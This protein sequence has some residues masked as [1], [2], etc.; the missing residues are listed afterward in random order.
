MRPPRFFASS[1]SSVIHAHLISRAL[2]RNM[3]FDAAAKEKF[4]EILARQCAFSQIELVTFCL[5]GNH[6]HLLVRLDT[7][8]PNP[9]QD[10]PDQALL[11]HLELIYRADEVQKVAWQLES[12]RSGGF[13]EA[14]AK[15]RQKYLDRMRNIPCFMQELKQRFSH[16]HNRRV[17]RKGTVWEDRYKSVLVEDSDTAVRTMAAYIDLNPV[18]AGIVDDPKDY[19]WSGY[20]EAVAGSGS[21]RA[22]LTRLVR[23]E[24]GED[25]AGGAATNWA[26]I[27]AIYRCWL[28]EEGAAVL[29]EHGKVIKRGFA[30]DTADAVINRQQGQLARRVLVRARL[31]HFTEGVAIG[32]REFIEEL[33]QARRTAFS[34][35][36]VDGS[37]KM[38]GV[39][40]GGLRSMRD[41]R[42]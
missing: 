12:F 15:L 35:R 11:D 25:P 26:R 6:F 29:D 23:T 3:I 36:R 4:R 42:G 10:A 33:F 34:P 14:A 13:A 28:Y 2:D 1:R 5:M 40:W 9:L 16:W 32:S 19:R 18:R 21:A 38:K 39:R 22:G 37:R 24:V 20:G 31:R 27:Q 7:A 30:P 41:L 8:E 17:R